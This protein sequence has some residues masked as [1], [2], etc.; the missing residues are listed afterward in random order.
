MTTTAAAA[1]LPAINTASCI[2]LPVE[3]L[4]NNNNQSL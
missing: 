4:H 2:M 3:A 1:L